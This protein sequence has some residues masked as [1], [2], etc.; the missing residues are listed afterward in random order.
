V[1]VYNLS[2]PAR[3]WQVDLGSLRVKWLI[4]MKWIALFRPVAGLRPL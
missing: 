1:D 2:V 3:V 4:Q